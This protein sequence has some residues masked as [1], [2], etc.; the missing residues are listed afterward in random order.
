MVK[1]E[2]V[3]Y[4]DLGEGKGALI[5]VS[6]ETGEELR[7]IARERGVEPSEIIMAALNAFINDP[8][9]QAEVEQRIKSKLEKG[10]SP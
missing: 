3:E 4:Q 5:T 7:E 8:G 2:D 9:V 6:G 10:E 1:D